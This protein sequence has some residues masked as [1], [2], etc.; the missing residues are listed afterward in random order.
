MRSLAWVAALVLAAFVVVKLGG[1]APDPRHSGSVS[2]GIAALPTYRSV[3]VSPGAVSCG[4]YAGGTSPNHSTPTQ[5]GL[6][7]GTCSVGKFGHKWPIKITYNGLPGYVYV[8]SSNA[9]PGDGRTPWDLCGQ[10]AG[11]GVACR[12]PGG[13]PGKYQ[14]TAENFGHYNF[15]TTVLTHTLV[16]DIA[17][18]PGGCYA[19][20]IRHHVQ[21]E[22]VDIIGPSWQDNPSTAWAVTVTWMAMPRA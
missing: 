2:V 4:Y 10:R 1:G 13:L 14:F 8:E 18:D 9:V 3:T 20:R 19:S 17:F 22:G 11:Q 12:G 6:P 21:V 16:C 7:N 5:L 15:G